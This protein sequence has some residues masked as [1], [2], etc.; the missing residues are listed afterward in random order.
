[1][2]DSLLNAFHIEKREG[3]YKDF[4]LPEDDPYP[5]RGVTYP[6][7]Y[8]YVD[9][10]KGE[11]G[12]ELDF[13]MGEGGDRSGYIVVSRPE[14]PH[15]E[16]KFYTNLTDDQVEKVLKEFIGAQKYDKAY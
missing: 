16:H 13:F 9:G 8:G 1:M 6:C 3:E 5:L 10:Y 2:N 7:N 11:D 14:L 15:G 12:A 4:G